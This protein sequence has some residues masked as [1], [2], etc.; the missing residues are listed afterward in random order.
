MDT[1]F[2][3]ED[4]FFGWS[5]DE[6]EPLSY[7]YEGHPAHADPAPATVRS[8]PPPL[9]I[10]PPAEPNELVLIRDA[11]VLATRTGGRG[12]VADR[13]WPSSGARFAKLT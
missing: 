1:P 7:L 3:E 2:C 12:T 4:E 13:L 5:F 6:L 10:P 11:P 9:D 8:P